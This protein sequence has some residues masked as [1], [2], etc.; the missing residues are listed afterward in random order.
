V[1]DYSL[2]DAFVSEEKMRELVERYRKEV[3]GKLV[4]GLAV[5][6]VEEEEQG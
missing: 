4:P 2:L 3:V 5:K 1:N 6:G